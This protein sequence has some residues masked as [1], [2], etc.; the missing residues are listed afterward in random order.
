MANLFNNKNLTELLDKDILEI[1]GGKNLPPEKK[2]E[3]YT[4]MAQTVQDRVVA[5][6]D[7][8]LDDQSR[9]E[10]IKLID[11]GDKVK[12]EEYLRSKNIDVAKLL[13]SEAIVYKMEIM[14]LYKQTQKQE[15]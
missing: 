11:E 9:Q 5:R 14:N 6:I 3:L 15:G 12:V 1:I 7:D 4:K 8:Q 13:V 10:F 2:Q